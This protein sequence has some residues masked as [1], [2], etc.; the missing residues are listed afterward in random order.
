MYDLE[1]YLTEIT[2][3]DASSLQPAAGAHGELAGMLLFY[4]YHKSKGAPRSKI[5]VPDTAHGTNPAS[6]ALCGYRSIPIKSNERGVLS[7]Q[8][9]NNSRPLRAIGSIVRISMDI[10]SS[11]FL[12]L[13]V[14][15][16][17]VR[18]EIVTIL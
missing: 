7:P 13:C 11:C 6:A 16:T 15:I 18:D 17:R 12:D 10:F 8:A 9:A 14:I 3:M 1:Q 2:A 5:I 4:A